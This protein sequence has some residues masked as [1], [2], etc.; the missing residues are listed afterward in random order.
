MAVQIEGLELDIK[1]N[2]EGAVQSINNLTNA[3]AKLKE[4]ADVGADLKTVAKALKDFSKIGTG[5][6]STL[7]GIQEAAEKAKEAVDGLATAVRNVNSPD[8]NGAEQA[9]SEATSAS[10]TEEGFKEVSN[11]F[12]GAAAIMSRARGVVDGIFGAFGKVAGAATRAASAVASFAAKI[13]GPLIKGA[14]SVASTIGNR[15]IGNLKNA[16]KV[17]NNFGSMVTRIIQRMAIRAAIKAVVEGLKE[18]VENLYQWSAATNGVFKASMDSLSTSFLY[19]KNSIG[20]AVAPIISALTPAINA[21]IDAI[22]TLINALNQLFSILGG[23]LSWTKAVKAPKEFAEAAGSAGGAAGKA[24]KEMKDFVMGFDELNLLKTPD[25]SGGGGGGGGGLTAEDYKLMFE[26]AE[27][28]DWAQMMKDKINMGDW[29]GAGRVLGGKVNALINSI[30]WVGAGKTFAAGFDHAIH[31]LFGFIDQI[32]FINL[33]VGIAQFANQIFDP[34]QVDWNMFGRLWGKK[35]TV[36]IDLIFGFV[37]QFNWENFGQS[38]LDGITGWGQEV[39][40]RLWILSLTISEAV[41]GLLT[42]LNIII[43]GIDWKSVGARIGQFLMDIDWVGIFVAVV[44]VAGNALKG[45]FDLLA[46]FVEQIDWFELGRTLVDGLGTAFESVDWDGVAGSFFELFGAALGGAVAFLGG[47]AYEVV[48]KIKDYFLQYINDENGDGQFGA[49]EIIS[50]LCQGIIDALANIGTWIYE[51]VLTPFINGFK[52]AFGI[53]S[54]STV[55]AEQGGYIVDGLKEGISNSWHNITEFFSEK[56]EAIKTSITEAWEKVKTETTT[57]WEQIKTSLSLTWFYLTGKIKETWE[58]FVKTITDKWE[59]VKTNTEEKWGLVKEQIDE[60]VGLIIEK[61]GEL[62]TEVGTNLKDAWDDAKDVVT[63]AASNMWTAVKDFA[64]DAIQK[65]KDLVSAIKEY[66]SA[67]KEAD[68]LEGQSSV[69]EGY[70]GSE[71]GGSYRTYN[72]SAGMYASGGFPP[73]GQL[74]ISREAG[75][76]MVGTIGGQTAVA[77]NDQI[78]AG[79]SSGVASANQSVVAALNVLINAVNSKDLT[80]AIGDDDIG[81]ANA[82]YTSSRGVS[83]NRGA[84]ANAY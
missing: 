74:F 78:V 17:V 69:S 51:N 42:S 82:R 36:L 32:D 50:G 16:T 3:L 8:I 73:E 9:V 68:G 5:N 41:T 31:F 70:G 27:Y 26:D 2:T 25:S 38:M 10:G 56:L 28:A 77:N 75:P 37:D 6:N 53:H 1:Q 40:S 35:I 23:A 76:E 49:G 84:F 39:E 80:V 83:V 66:I 57:K 64:T 33:G 18:G 58:N 19:L 72:S 79:I 62:V 48:T 4:V 65:F 30:D 46:G 67:W 12:S 34:E 14:K 54:P 71:H 44:T 20:A 55:M 81:R 21:A 43:T 11:G 60:K 29:E 47:V 24:A 45:A 63:T 13:G 15:L 59:E 22:V 61:I 52:S 7:K